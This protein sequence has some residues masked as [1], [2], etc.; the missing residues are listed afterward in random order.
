M[1]KRILSLIGRIAAERGVA[2]VC[3]YGYGVTNRAILDI[4]KDETSVELSVLHKQR[5]GLPD[6]I[7]QAIIGSSDRLDYDIIFASP[8][9]RRESLVTGERTL[10]TSDTDLFFGGNPD[11]C[12]LVSGS[13]GKS[14]V[15]TL[16]AELL[17]PRYPRAFVGGNLGTPPAKCDLAA[18]RGA[19]IELSSFQLRYITPRS[20]RAIITNITPNHLDW[21]SDYD[22]YVAAKKGLLTKCDEPIINVDTPSCAEIAAQAPL[23]AVCSSRLSHRELTSRYRAEHTVTADDGILIDGERILGPDGVL[24]KGAHNL[25]NLASAVAMTLGMVN[26]ERIREVAES[27]RGL[28]H[29]CEH[30]LTADG[31]DFIN[32]SIDTTPERTK[33]TLEAYDRPVRILLGGR[34]KGLSPEPLREPLRRYARRISI[35]GEI[36]E[37]LLELI[38]S[39]AELRRIP[40]SRFTRFTDALEYLMQGLEYGDAVILSPA[41]TSYG[42][43]ISYAER[44]AHFKELIRKRYEKI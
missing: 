22:E 29:R 38:E 10:V 14:T 30:F 3:L 39:D 12:F 36:G 37:E 27:F 33:A 28:E 32:S 26:T 44:G 6:G 9:V 15:T 24:L 35:Y 2:R 1:K 31:T 19:V 34:G 23:F 4:L 11:E 25:D 18:T 43:F 41:A 13:S 8:S 21:H 17:R 20:K 7:A 42:E 40:H 16:T 5:V